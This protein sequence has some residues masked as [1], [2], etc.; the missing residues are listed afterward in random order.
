MSSNFSTSFW[1]GHESFWEPQKRNHFFLFTEIALAYSC[2]YFFKSLTWHHNASKWKNCGF[3]DE[4]HEFVYEINAIICQSFR[5]SNSPKRIAI[6]VF[7]EKLPH[8]ECVA[9]RLHLNPSTHTSFLLGLHTFLINDREWYFCF[10]KLKSVFGC[11]V[12]CLLNTIR[13]VANARS[14]RSTPTCQ[15]II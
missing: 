4:I 8:S 5:F 12:F 14:T 15:N 13:V 11:Q 9:R 2:E 10:V 1:I 6:D 3:H 7:C